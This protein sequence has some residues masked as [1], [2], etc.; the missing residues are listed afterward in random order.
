MI[1]FL[2]LAAFAVALFDAV[3]GLAWRVDAMLGL[4]AI[5]AMGAAFMIGVRIGSARFWRLLLSDPIEGARALRELSG[6]YGR[7]ARGGP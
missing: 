6:R 1:T 4:I 7:E 2:F 3:V 5:E